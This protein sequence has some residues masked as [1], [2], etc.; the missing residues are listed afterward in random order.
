MTRLSIDS[1]KNFSLKCLL[2]EE[3]KEIR[4]SEFVFQSFYELTA[5]LIEFN[6][7]FKHYLKFLIFSQN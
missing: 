2:S 5:D 3:S 6:F 7:D 4:V 1:I